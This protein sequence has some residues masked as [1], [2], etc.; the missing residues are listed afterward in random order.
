MSQRALVT[1]FRMTL[2]GGVIALSGC[3]GK[4]FFSP[5]TWFHSPLVISD[6]GVGAITSATP[7]N[8]NVINN[9][10]DDRYTIR[11]G[12]Q[13]ENGD[14]VSVFQAMKD[15][16]VAV[17]VFGPE[18]GTVS[19]VVVNDADM[20][21]EW[22]IQIGSEFNDIYQKAYG[23]CSLGEVIDSVPTVLCVAPQSSK[24][25]YRFSGKWQGPENL[26]P[27]DEVLKEWKVSQIIWHK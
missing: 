11:G 25:V 17:E 14:M 5:S 3:A 27:A 6:A 1:V 18:K 21:T 22:G 10:L 24:V 9:Q 23:S 2:L 19:R 8:L 20:I 26:M 4:G 16:D 13:M 12:M 15:L 7:M